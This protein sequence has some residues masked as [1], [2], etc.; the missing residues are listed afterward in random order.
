MS[1]AAP[2]PLQLFRLLIAGE[3]AAARVHFS[4]APHVADPLEGVSAG[5]AEWTRFARAK[6][7]W[8]RERRARLQ[9]GARTGA[10]S[11]VV[12]EATLQLRHEGRAVSLPLAI[13]ADVAAERWSAV[14]IYHSLWPLLGHHRVRP[15]LLP[16]DPAV[17]LPGVIGAY[18]AALRAGS[19]D[20]ILATFSPAGY[21]REPSGG[22]FVHQGAERLRAFY[23]GLFSGGA[24]IGLEYCTFTDD[25]VR[26]ALE[27]TCVQWGATTVPP[28][29]GLAVYERGPSGLLSAARIYDDVTPP[30]PASG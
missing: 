8:L 7:T 2:D 23:G 29:A 12:G 19:L 18:H 10:G 4:S 21:A 11:R 15:P 1:M 13:V 28:Q 25:G 3:I 14:R 24:G 6:S 30:E 9:P 16:A 20:A 26:G 22:A 5:A 17:A 27:Y